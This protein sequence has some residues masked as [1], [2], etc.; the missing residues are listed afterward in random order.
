MMEIGIGGNASTLDGIVTEAVATESAG[1]AT[2]SISNIFG[3]D[4]ISALTIAATH[5]SRI[6]LLTAVVP[7][8]PVALL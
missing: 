1:L 8:L 6:E 5:T 4:A 2:F 3:H 7:C